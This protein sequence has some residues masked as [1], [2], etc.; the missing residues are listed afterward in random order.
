MW[1][2]PFM[3]TAVS[4]C[5]I[6]K[7]SVSLKSTNSH[8]SSTC[9]SLPGESKYGE[10]K[11]VS[12]QSVPSHSRFSFSLRSKCPQAGGDFECV[13]QEQRSGALGH[14]G[15]WQLSHYRHF[16][17]LLFPWEASVKQWSLWPNPRPSLIFGK[18]KRS[19]SLFL[20][21]FLPLLPLSL[22]QFL[23]S[24]AQLSALYGRLGRQVGGAFP[25]MTP[26]PTHSVSWQLQGRIIKLFLFLS[27][28]KSLA[29]KTKT[30]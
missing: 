30:L 26:S 27:Q 14:L 17:K 1:E 23:Q 3:H 15:W 25:V 4:F 5:A 7:S 11:E 16:Q 29:R 13:Q 8:L 10:K 6:I 22:S 2:S 21:L 28:A 9:F 20:W 19:L 24:T 12:R 18:A